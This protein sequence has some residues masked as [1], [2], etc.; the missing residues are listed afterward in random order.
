ML[1]TIEQAGRALSKGGE[2]DSAQDQSLLSGELECE[3]QGLMTA[4]NED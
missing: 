1:V 2:G 3:G 4:T